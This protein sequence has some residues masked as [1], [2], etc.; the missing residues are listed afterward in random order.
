MDGALR[1]VI[2]RT[3]MPKMRSLVALV[4]VL[5]FAAVPTLTSAPPA[6]ACSGSSASLA[7]GVRNA[8]SIYYARIV[9]VTPTSV[10]FN[11]LRL[12]VEEVVDG[13]A[14]SHVTR[15]IPNEACV[16]IR[17][18]QVGVVVLGSVDPFRDGRDDVYNLFFAIGPGRT[19]RAEAE[20]AL[21]VLP[22]A[23]DTAAAPHVDPGTPQL[24]LVAV[25]CFSFVAALIYV[26]RRQSTLPRAR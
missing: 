13:P 24:P 19:S 3:I 11:S 1:Q 18:G 10:G 9:T 6:S 16:G 25:A 26:R 12:D 17:V 2:R 23:T 8:G 14:P 7:D 5:G 22:P 20:A 21:G 15:V 4:L